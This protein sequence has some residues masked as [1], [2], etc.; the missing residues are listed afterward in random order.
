MTEIKL[1][2]QEVIEVKDPLDI[3]L[4]PVLTEDESYKDEESDFIPESDE[5][6][7]DSEEIDIE[8]KNR[9]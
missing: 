1:E 3:K 6:S 7:E 8:G 5:K 2:P 9:I 4:E